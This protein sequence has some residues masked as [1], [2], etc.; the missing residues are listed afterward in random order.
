[1]TSI[2]ERL[3]RLERRVDRYRDLAACLGGML[4]LVVTLG[5]TGVVSPANNAVWQ[6]REARP[7]RSQPRVAD[8]Q[9]LTTDGAAASVQSLS[10][11][12]TPTE[13]IDYLQV[14]RLQLVN[15]EGTVLVDLAESTGGSGLVILYNGEGENTVYVGSSAS[16]G[17]GL[18]VVNSA[19][20]ETLI[21]LGSDADTGGGY[22]NIRNAQEA[23]LVSLS[24]SGDAGHLNLYDTQ[25]DRLFYAGSNTSGHGLIQVGNSEGKGLLSLWTDEDSGTLWIDN[26]QDQNVVYLGTD[27]DG[28][29]LLNVSSKN[30][31]ELIT[32]GSNTSDN[33]L[34][35]VSNR[36]GNLEF[37]V[38]AGDEYGTAYT[39]DAQQNLLVDL[40][41][42]L[43][44][45]GLIQTWS[46]MGVPVWSSNL[47]GG[48]GG[49]SPSGVAGDL[50]GDGD[51]DG[52]DFLIFSENYGKVK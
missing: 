14:K 28:Q 22:L 1:M 25:G 47:L 20:E 30:G 21:S 13:S 9:S 5:A 40:D 49:V 23:R 43:N 33:G 4:A 8:Q 42:D 2:E 26:N 7:R 17:D 10:K 37:V 12:A 27:V 41:V 6:A 19:E 48:A 16:S 24:T 32:A 31:D 46:P 50:D 29:G 36:F 52:S 39:M 38:I 45:N 3:N 51:V 34:F 35:R 11:M 44:G 15:D 18:L